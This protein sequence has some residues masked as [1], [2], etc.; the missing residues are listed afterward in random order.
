MMNMPWSIVLIE[1]NNALSLSFLMQVPLES[2]FMQG[3]LQRKETLAPL[4]SPP[5][6]Q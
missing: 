3:L 6:I 2:D 4:I 5:V 1:I